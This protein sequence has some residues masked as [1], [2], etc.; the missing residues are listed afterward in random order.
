MHKENS[1]TDSITFDFC[2]SWALQKELITSYLEKKKNSTDVNNLH[3]QFNSESIWL[4]KVSIPERFS[5]ERALHR[6]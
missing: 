5:V 6:T 2:F 3:V 4:P 1:H